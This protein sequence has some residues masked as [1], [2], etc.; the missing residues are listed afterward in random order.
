MFTSRPL[1]SLWLSEPYLSWAYLNL[2]SSG[3]PGS[4]IECLWDFSMPLAAPSAS[5]LWKWKPLS[6]VRLFVT[7]WTSQGRILCNYHGRILCNSHGRILEWV[8]F[9]FSRES[10]QPRDRTQVSHIE[11]GFITSWATREAQEHWSGWPISSAG[12]LPNPGTEPRSPSFRQILYHL[13]HKGSPGPICPKRGQG[14][15]R[16]GCNFVCSDSSPDLYLACFHSQIL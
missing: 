15:F 13:S 1:G 10:S 8:A 11:G 2:S 4:A 12:N 14:V 9:S 16:T 7:P 3:G 5:R 6:H